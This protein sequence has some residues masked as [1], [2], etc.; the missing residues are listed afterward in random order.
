M[1]RAMAAAEDGDDCHGDDP[2][3]NSLRVLVTEMLGKEVAVFMPTGTMSNQ[4]EIRSHTEPG[5]AV[6]PNKGIQPTRKS[7]R[8]LPGVRR[9]CLG[10]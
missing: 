10:S 5:D 4:V 3:I 7:A 6:R 1:R 2:T 8:L 9:N